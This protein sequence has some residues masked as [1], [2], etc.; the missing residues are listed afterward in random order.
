MDIEFLEM[1]L[2]SDTY[3]NLKVLNIG[4][5]SFGCDVRTEKNFYDDLLSRFINLEVLKKKKNKK[6][7]FFTGKKKILRF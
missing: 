3:P 6:I 1:E 4:K 5:S 7:Q 2:A